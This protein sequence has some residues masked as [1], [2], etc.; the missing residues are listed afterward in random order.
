MQCLW[1]SDVVSRFVRGRDPIIQRRARNYLNR[2]QHATI[3]LLTKYEVLRG[4]KAQRANRLLT[5]LQSFCQ[6][7]S[8]LPISESII[9]RTAEL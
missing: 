7:S 3:S 5:L 4:W 2:Y 6:Q 9:D 8:I 1:D